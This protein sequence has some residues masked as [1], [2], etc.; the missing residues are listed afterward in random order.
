MVRLIKSHTIYSGNKQ[1][2]SRAQVKVFL[3]PDGTVRDAQ[4]LKKM[5]D[6]AYAEA[7]R[8]AVMTTQK[9][10]PLPKGKSFSNMRE[11]TLSFCAREELKECKM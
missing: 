4:I 7:A 8:R 10:P 6:P 11:W 2:D 5:G 1:V 3:L 9:F